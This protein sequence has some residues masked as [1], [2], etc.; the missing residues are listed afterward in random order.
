[1]KRL[2]DTEGKSIPQCCALLGY[3]KQA[4]YKRLS[5][6]EQKS[7]RERLLLKETVSIRRDMPVLGGRKLLSVI[8]KT[9][10]ES[11]CIGRDSFFRLLSRNG[12]LVR[13]RRSSHPSTTMSW[14]H[15]HKYPNLCR[16]A[17]PETPNRIWVADITYL[18]KRSGGF[19][20]LSLLTDLYSHKIVGWHLSEN[21]GLEGPL[22]ALENALSGLPSRHEGLIHHSDRGI[23]YCSHVYTGLLQSYGIRISMTENGN[24]RENAVAERVNG[25]LKEEWLNR[26]DIISIEDGMHKVEKVIDIYNSRRP[27]LSNGML[28]PED[29]HRK[30]G[31]LERKWKTYYKKR[32]TLDKLSEE[33]LN[34]SVKEESQ[35]LS[36]LESNK[37]KQSTNS[38]N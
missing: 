22:H 4:Y 27:H 8:R 16:G 12:L 3:S 13:K 17:I 1:M 21:L 38:S 37:K 36:G 6:Q 29:A 35:L 18:R 34:L 20:Y 19:L 11:L 25:I 15:F 9:I 2:H 32:M 31:M 28:T 33:K 10:P 5:G 7:F 24:P 23:Q 30:S 14:H 26:E